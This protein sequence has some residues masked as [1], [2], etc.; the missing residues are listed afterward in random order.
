MSLQAFREEYTECLLSRFWEQW[1]GLGLFAAGTAPEVKADKLVAV[2]DPEALLLASWELGR[3]D[4]RLY[5]EVLS[6]LVSHGEAINLKRLGNLARQQPEL[7]RSLLGAPAAWLLKISG[8]SRWKRLAGISRPERP[9]AFFLDPHG[10]PLPGWGEQDPAFQRAGWLRGPVHLRDLNTGISTKSAA[11]LWLRLRYL[12]GLNIR[13]DVI[14]YLLTHDSAHPS[15]LSRG[16]HYSQ[17]SLFRVCQ[18]MESSGLVHSF[19]QGN[20]RRYQL[21]SEHWQTFLGTRPVR[22]VNWAAQFRFHQYMWRFLYGRNWTGVSTYLQASELRAALQESLRIG[23][24]LELPAEFQSVFDLP[25]EAF[26]TP[27]T[28]R[29]RDFAM[30]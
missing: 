22:W 4:P 8:D 30:E 29:L 18:E 23:G 3:M 17:P 19:R 27:A 2:I 25:G 20:Q 13:A 24:I 10:Q 26:L 11:T 21:K 28:S 16:V 1:A 6:W 15:E 7:D 5:D 14:V 9:A 12:F